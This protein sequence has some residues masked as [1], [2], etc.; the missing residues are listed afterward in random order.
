MPELKQNEKLA[1]IRKEALEVLA[2]PESAI[3]VDGAEF[4][5]ALE[6]GLAKVSVTAIKSADYDAVAEHE[7]WVEDVARK[8]A[9]ATAKKAKAEADKAA[10]IARKAELKARK[11]AEKA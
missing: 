11:E 4:V 10:D 6:H 8:L 9:V 3:Q 1:L 2:L 5:L 7:A